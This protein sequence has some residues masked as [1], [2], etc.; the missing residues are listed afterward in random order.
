M[1]EGTEVLTSI[2]SD[3]A[4]SM[5]RSYHEGTLSLTEPFLWNEEAGL[6]DIFKIA[7][8]FASMFALVSNFIISDRITPF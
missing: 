5:D 2:D 7:S 4:L 8:Y 3:D 1:K 6:N